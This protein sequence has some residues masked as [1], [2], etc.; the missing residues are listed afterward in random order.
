MLKYDGLEE[1]EVYLVKK[2]QESK[3]GKE[4]EGNSIYVSC[5]LEK[6]AE[7]IPVESLDSLRESSDQ[8]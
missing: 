4:G 5:N 6:S 1:M 7:S 8:A 3:E 2:W